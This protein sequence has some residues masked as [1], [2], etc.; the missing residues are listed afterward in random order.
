[1]SMIKDFQVTRRTVL[2]GAGALVVTISVPVSAA[3]T[4]ARA[5]GGAGVKP[6][7][8]PDELDSFVRIAEDGR[9]TAYFGK[10]D[11][12]QG[13]DVAIGQIVAEEL[14][15][16]FERVRVVMGDTARTVDQGGGSGSS[17]IQRGGVPLRNAA[18][19]A[20]RI[21]LEL[22]AIRLKTPARYLTVADGVIGVKG[23]AAR[24][25]SYSELIGGHY[26]NVKLEWNKK[27]GNRL[28]STGKAKPK[29]REQYKVVGK[30]VPR[31]DIAGKVFGTS[32][33]ITDITV[34]G[35]LHGRTVRPP[36]AG[37][38]PISVD[39]SS[40]SHIPGVRVVS[41]G[42]FLGVV[43]VKEWDAVKAAE[44]L[45]VAWSKV[46]PPFPDQKDLYDHIRKTPTL[47]AKLKAKDTGDVD[48]AFKGAA[49]VIEAE[50]EWP[51]QSHASMG[52]A[53]AIVE[54]KD[55]EATVWTGSQKPHSTA[56]GVAKILKLKRE[57]VR[58]IWVMGPGSYGRNDAG[59]GAMDAAI[60]SKAVGRPVRIQG[61]RYEGTGWDPKAPASV[62]TVLGGLDA[63]GNVIAY[64]FHS[65]AFD[66]QNVRSNEADPSHTLAGQ[67]T[68]YPLKPR[69][70][71]RTPAESYDFPNKRLGWEIIPP[72]LERASP[73]RT[74]HFRDP[75]GPQLHFAS[76]SF[77]DEM[78]LAA[79]ADPVAFRLKYIKKRIDAEVVKAAAE[80]SGWKPR[81]GPN[82]KPG[83]TG[84]V[85][86]RGIAYA[87][88]NGAVLAIVAEVEV[89]RTTGRVWPRKYTV[90][91]ECGLI[92]NPDGL[93]RCIEG[94]VVMATSRMLWEE[95][96]FDNDNVTSVDWVS[97]PILESVD[98]PEEIDIVLIDRP[99]IAPKGAG[100]P[101]T[102]PVA[103]A[104]ANAFFDAT[105]VRLRRAPYTPER[106]KAALA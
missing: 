35:M 68:G 70:F 62:H 51:F 9:V 63:E 22:A 103:G 55:G 27:M 74:S 81:V 94:N 101:S 42:D 77:I 65:K 5:K 15:V 30:S 23:E 11:M 66:R 29:K 10:M 86:G 8:K 41:Q 43:A 17:G 106:V 24:K 4:P 100:E 58:G 76:E 105:G 98:A 95:V 36:K 44:T 97:Y 33:F 73:L 34:P 7:L 88:R 38:S 93:R 6:P 90:A 104:I 1:M 31:N 61:M 50:Y 60:L 47:K 75:L 87:Q 26:F 84:T 21:L 89:D 67:L 80:K 102:R 13:V 72:L 79:D 14:D 16:P 59:D 71:F 85:S 53:C 99:G 46:A 48:Q 40:I 37:A 96:M 19:E 52:P 3:R 78:A 45:K 92:I 20:R 64:H 2:K 12:G 69:K 39:E 56:Q 25:V 82:N 91:H 83:G 18:A 28:V 49:K 54:A 32:D 57:Q